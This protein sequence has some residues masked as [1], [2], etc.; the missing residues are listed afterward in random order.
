MPMAPATDDWNQIL[1]FAEEIVREGGAIA[2]KHYG[3]ADPMLKF[4]MSLVT[5]AD[6]EVQDHLETKIGEMFPDHAFLGEERGSKAVEHHGHLWVVDP[7][8]GTAAFSS[9]LPIWGVSLS[10]F[11]EG[12]LIFGVFYMPATNEMYT[13]FGKKAFHNGKRIMARVDDQVDNE[14]V[15]LT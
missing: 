10:H 3:N 14:S 12:K 4:D 9:E 6:L 13:G 15:L 8:D 7:V 11:F 2:L 5:E 1:H